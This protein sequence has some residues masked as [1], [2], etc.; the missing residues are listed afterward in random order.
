MKTYSKLLIFTFVIFLS[1]CGEDFLTLSPQGTVFSSEFF[2]NAEEVEQALI[3]AYDV[4]GHQKGVGLAWAPQLFLTEVLSDDALAGGQD[5][6]DGTLSNEFNTFSFS[7]NN[8]VVRSLWKKGYTGIFRANFTID[9]AEQLLD[10]EEAEVLQ[11]IIAEARFLRAYYYF[12]LLRFFENVPLIPELPETVDADNQPQADPQEVYDFIAS[13]LVFAINNLPENTR[14]LR[15]TKWSAQGLLA[16]VFLFKNGVYGGDLDADGQTVNDAFC[17]AQ[18]ENMINT[19]GHELM[20]VYDS[21]F[22]QNFEFNQESVFEIAFERGPVRGDW[23]SE[24]Q[25]EGNLAAQ[26]MGPR[27]STSGTYYRGWSF[28]VMTNKLFQDMQ[29]DPRLNATILTQ[30]TILSEPGAGL[31]TG[32]FQHTGLYNNKYTTRIVDRGP[33]GTPELHNTTNIRA[34][35][36]ADVLLMAAELG[37][38]VDYINQVRARVGLA[39][40]AAYTEEALFQERRMELAGEGIRYLDLIRRGL[41]VASQELTTTGDIGPNYTGPDNFYDVTFNQTTR[42]F[43]PIPQVEIDL[44]A[45]VLVQNEGF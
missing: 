18:L 22:L 39:P 44:S 7:T 42:G 19:S 4:L 14:S 43:I 17:L 34:I 30:E 37:Q 9:R 23:G 1:G 31:N 32:A 29:G 33:Q 13:D 15:A 16:R 38:N 25:V 3:S 11:E 10:G 40:L 8:E 12:E 27:A 21:I 41:G 36:F 28:G 35:R 20:P 26:M 6:G 2:N 45:G 24:H 5:P